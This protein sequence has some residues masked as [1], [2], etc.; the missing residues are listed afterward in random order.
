MIDPIGRPVEYAGFDLIDLL[1]GLK[2]RFTS[3][4]V[5]T[6]HRN[7]ETDEETLFTGTKQTSG[8]SLEFLRLKT[9]VTNYANLTWPGDTTELP[10]L[11]NDDSHLS[12]D[13]GR[14]EILFCP[15]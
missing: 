14:S 1:E 15:L 4:E 3:L 13:I 11:L 9:A 5:I 6:V 2:R 12:G 8:S 7:S 10:E